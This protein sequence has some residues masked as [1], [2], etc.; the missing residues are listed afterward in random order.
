MNVLVTGA[1]GYVGGRLVPRL[2]EQ[3]HRVRVLLREGSSIHGRP[4]ADR[5]EIF[6]GDLLDAGTLSGL[7]DGIDAAYYL[8]HA[9]WAGKDFAGRDRLAAENFV[10]VASDVAHVVY[11]GGLQPEGDGPVSLHLSSRA[12]VGEVL[13]DTLPTTEF[14][15]GPI[16]GSGS[17]SF[18]M[19]RYLTE[20][21]PVMVAPK[22]VSNTVQPI[23][24]RDVLSYLL[25]ALDTGPLGVVPIGADR[26]TF[27][28]MML[29]Y[30]A[31]RGLSRLIVPVPVLAPKLAARWV[32]AVTPI[33][34]T[35]AVPLVAGVARP[36]EADTTR[37]SERFKQIE[38][39]AYRAAVRYALQRIGSNSVETRWT[40]G[41][42]ELKAESY[43]HRDWEG[44]IREER[45]IAVDA[46]PQAVFNAF[47]SLGGDR[48]WLAWNW[49][50]SVRGVIDAL[51]GGPGLRRGRRHPHELLAGEALD[52]WRVESIDPPRLLRLRA[53]MKVPGRAWLQF[54]AVE[55]DNHT[56]L[57]QT[58]LFQPSGLPGVL[59]W[60]TLY[61]VHRI[62]FT[63]MAK[64]L[65]KDAM[66]RKADPTPA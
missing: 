46:P 26:L 63:A 39:I 34:N 10:S 50:W 38:P 13:A 20:R 24:I 56:R 40:G 48:G 54:E 29:Q 8:V 52:W 31:E 22:W 51:V 28:D 37:A 25:A 19:V 42:S 41:Q 59:Y 11:L 1:T 4:W 3:G 65:A 16:I 61:P 64:R 12:E 55:E 27:K 36:L 45:S 58:A 23:A 49:A 44:I 35:L 60:Y 62:I 5:V 21:L 66:S 53:E 32:G 9:M 6:R 47:S 30:A 33:P 14:R 57:V 43:E 18:E 7:C 17:A 15:A 2:L